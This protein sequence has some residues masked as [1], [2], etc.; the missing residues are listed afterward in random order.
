MGPTYTPD[1]NVYAAVLDFIKQGKPAALATVLEAEGSTPQVTGALALFSEDGLAAGT[2]GGGFVEAEVERRAR[3][4]LRT[5][6]SRHCAFNLGDRFFEDA[7]G[8]CGGE[9]RILIDARPDESERAFRESVD[10]FRRR[11]PGILATRI[12]S[13]R[14]GLACIKR[15]WIPATRSGFG[16]RR[17]LIKIAAAELTRVLSQ[18]RPEYS[19]KRGYRLFL[20][21]HVPSPRLLIAGA[22]HVARAV[23]HQGRLLGF[24]VIVIDDRP[25][26][27]DLSRIPDAERVLVGDIAARLRS[28]PMDNDTYVVIVTRGHRHDA[29]ALRMCIRRRTAYVGMIGSRRKI[30]LM[31]D[32]FMEKRWSS[33]VAWE[34]VHA[35]I[36]L[37]IGSRTVNEI[38]VSIAA[39]L[40]QVRRRRNPLR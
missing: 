31:R 33:P 22:G 21:P 16:P 30:E 12:V 35:P 5:R 9:M 40:V 18:G 27:A 3:R 29:D 2:V 26:F 24:E 14:S 10:A 13:T 39:E 36:G 15:A 32:R 1:R 11:Q 34:R 7:D 28:F 6:L 25:D 20:E 17:G 23:A 19:R 37:P 4:A 8:L 38:A